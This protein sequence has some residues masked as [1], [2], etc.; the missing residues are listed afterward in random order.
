MLGGQGRI[1]GALSPGLRAQIQG[2]LRDGV[3]LVATRVLYFVGI[4]FNLLSKQ[5]KER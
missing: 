4:Y 2:D 5:Q 3:V 1:G